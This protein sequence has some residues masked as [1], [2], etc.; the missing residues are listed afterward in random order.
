MNTNEKLLLGLIAGAAAGA[1]I[2]ILFAPDKG[3][4]TREKI[5]NLGKRQKDLHP[6]SAQSSTVKE[7]LIKRGKSESVDENNMNVW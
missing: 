3:S 5:M 4:A 6:I 2:A 7:D 1:T